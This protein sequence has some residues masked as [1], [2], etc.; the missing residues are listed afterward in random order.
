MANISK[1]MTDVANTSKFT[2]TPNTPPLISAFGDR[3]AARTGS[4]DWRETTIDRS[5]AQAA[6]E[7]HVE[8]G[9]ENGPEMESEFDGFLEQAEQGRSFGRERSRLR[10]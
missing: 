2:D 6:F 7:E 8:S 1:F 5:E 9:M 10:S 3:M 4:R